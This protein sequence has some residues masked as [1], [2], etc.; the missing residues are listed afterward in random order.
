MT[1]NISAEL[2]CLVSRIDPSTLPA[3][4]GAKAAAEP[5]SIDNESQLFA[6]DYLIARMASLHRRLN[7]PLKSREP[8]LVADRPW[9]GQGLVYGCVVPLPSG[10]RLYYRGRYNVPKEH[11]SAGSG[12]QSESPVCMAQSDDAVSFRK[13]A[14]RDAAVNGTNV[15]IDTSLDDFTVLRDPHDADERR[16]FKLLASRGNWWPGLTPATSPD[17]IRWTWGQ[18]HAVTWFGDRCSYWYDPVNR[19]HVAWSRNYKLTGKRVIVHKETA[20]FDHWSDERV[21]PVKLAL[22]PDRRDHE[23]TQFYGGYGFWYRSLYFAYVEVYYIHY[24]RLDTQLACSRDGRAWTRIDDGDIFLPNGEHGEFDGYWI[25]P[26]FNAPIPHDGKLLIHYNGRPDPHPQPGFRHIPPGMGGAFALA[27]LR[28]DGFVSLD[29]TGAEGIVET[30][31]LK[32]QAPWSVLEVNCCPFATRPRLAPMDVKVE[33]LSEHG[34]PLSAYALRP[35]SAAGHTW[36]RI[37]LD[38]PPPPVFRLRFRLINARLYSFRL[39]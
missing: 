26:T 18:D 12:P 28:E 38:A 34:A 3:P 2:D 17:G 24:Q 11:G 5:L 7:R 15:V 36:Y 31:A 25:V 29:A 9:E 22:A 8:F 13:E 6:D 1:D 30:K 16:R 4:G 19:K 39:R 23:Q 33:V 14:L 21:S 27:T 32:P 37:G 35:A 10:Y 20:D